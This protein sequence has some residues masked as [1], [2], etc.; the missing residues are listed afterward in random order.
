MKR[1]LLLLL[2]GCASAAPTPVA[3]SAP[4]TKAVATADIPEPEAQLSPPSSPDRFATRT[5]FVEEAPR[6]TGRK[7]D[8]DL[9]DADVA[10]V[11][12]LLADV[13]NTNI[14]LGDGVQGHVTLTMH[15]VP[16]D[17]ALDSVLR[18][19][20]LR[21]ERDGNVILVFAK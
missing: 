11:C 16:W 17:Q 7:I 8:L 4:T 20:G 9:K 6:Y 19:K 14:V 10:N 18:A 3:P 15:R 21:A 5:L 12:R 2:L 1:A 13:G